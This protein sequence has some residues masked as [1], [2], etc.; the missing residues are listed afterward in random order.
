VFLRD[1]YTCR[2]CNRALLPDELECDHIIPTSKGGTDAMDNLATRCITC[3]EAK[4]NRE[5]GITTKARIGADG[6][7]E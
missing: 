7:P 4:T 3:H 5:M 2:D 6:W 1:G